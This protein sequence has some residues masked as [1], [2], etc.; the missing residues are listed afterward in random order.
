[1]STS[2]VAAPL[3]VKKP[4]TS[5][6][7]LWVRT[8]QPRQTGMDHWKGPHSGIIS[9]TPGLE[10]YRQIHLAE[11]NTGLWPAIDGVQTAI[12][13]ERKIDGVAEVT[14]QSALAPLK[15]RKQ[16]KLAYADEINVF[17]RTL[18]YTGP[19]NSSRWYDVAGP[20]QTVGARTL[21]Y[22]RRRDGVGAGAFR[23]FVNEQLAPALAGTGVLKELRT[24]TFLPWTKKLWDTP[25]VAHDNP[26]DQHFHASVSLG[27]TDTAA[28]DA[29][30]TGNAIED[31]SN[32]L[33]PQVSAIHAYDVAAALTYV[34][35]GD[36]LPH[37]EE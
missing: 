4:L 33:A 27:F 24:Q 11:H 35:N 14:F 36:I 34:K 13:A 37:Y 31:L 8:D 12:P 26:H 10:E 6:I 21:I 32:R 28:R 20:G 18:L 15:G 2:P 5:S 1:M 30:F 7:L 29:F 9:A 3:E 19:P 25:S 23:K 16:T 22:L 17:R